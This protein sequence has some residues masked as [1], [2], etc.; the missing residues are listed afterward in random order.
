MAAT[1]AQDQP[2]FNEPKS[3]DVEG[4]TPQEVVEVDELD[5]A[6]RAQWLRAAILGLVGGACSMAIGELVSVYSKYDIEMSQMKRD[7][8]IENMGADELD[9]EKEK[10]PN[11]WHAAGA[12]ALAFSWGRWC[13]Y[14]PLPF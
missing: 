12:S 4:Q 1:Q 10:L 13:R 14:S 6:K 2:S 8:K 5:Y 9:A 11:P 3:L 7:G